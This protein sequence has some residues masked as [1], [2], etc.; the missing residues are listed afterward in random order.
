MQW[1]STGTASAAERSLRRAIEL[2]PRTRRPTSGTARRSPSPVGSSEAEGEIRRALDLDPLSLVINADLGLLAYYAR[3]YERAIEYYQATRWPWSRTSSLP[4]SAS[5]SHSRSSATTTQ[6]LAELAEARTVA[7][8]EPVVLAALAY[9]PAAPVVAAR[10]ARPSPRS[11][12]RPAAT[13]RRRR[14]TSPAAPLGLG[15]VDAALSWLGKAADARCSLLGSLAVDPAFDPL[16]N[17]PRFAE[18]LRCAGL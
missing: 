3:D 5:R 12:Q 1:T 13:L 11:A 7:V 8:D 17:D 9:V 4:G 14:T 15:D 18:L 16:R 6:A 2:A 10:P